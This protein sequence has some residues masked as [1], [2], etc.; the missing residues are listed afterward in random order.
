MAVFPVIFL[1]LP[2]LILLVLGAI[3][4]LIVWMGLRHHR[5]SG[6]S[7]HEREAQAR[8][9][10]ELHETAERLTRRLESVETILLDQAD[11]PIRERTEAGSQSQTL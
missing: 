7:R 2:V 10:Q 1:L 11:P 3:A 4:L 8:A 5:H 6:A 9:V